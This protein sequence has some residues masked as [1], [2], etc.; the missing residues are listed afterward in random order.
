MKKLACI[1]LA[2]GCVALL[3]ASCAP[4]KPGTSKRA[5][6][7]KPYDFK[8]EGKIPPVEKTVQPE[9]DVEELVVEELPVESVEAE[10]PIDTTSKIDP[11]AGRV[12]LD[13]FRVQ[14]FASGAEDVAASARAAAASRLGVMAYVE[15]VD[16]LY[17]VRVG[18]CKTREQAQALLARCQDSYYTDAWIVECRIYADK[19]SAN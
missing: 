7:D 12:M 16:G 15:L 8:K 17:K 19:S 6:M 4:A 5:T 18:D 14:V 13:G 9:P 2:L 11:N 1:F 10:A 3:L